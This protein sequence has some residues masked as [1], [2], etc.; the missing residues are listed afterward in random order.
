VQQS[1]IPRR[2]FSQIPR[3][4]LTGQVALITGPAKGMGHDIT[5]AIAREGADCI[6]A[7]RDL[8]AIHPVAERIRGLGRRAIVVKCDITVESDAKAAVASGVAEFGRIDCFVHVVGVHVGCCHP[9]CSCASFDR[10]ATALQGPCETPGWLVDDK[11]FEDVFSVNVKGAFHMAKAIAPVMIEK[12]GGRIVFLGGTYGMKAAPGRMVYAASKWALRG[13]T[14][15]LAAELGKHNINVNIVEPVRC[16]CCC[17]EWFCYVVV[18][19]PT[20][21][22]T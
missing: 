2:V 13:M 10:C 11:D 8:D 4:D 14:K 12:G 22:V 3:G 21:T 16:L 6:L 20:K 18:P 9:A 17:S 15:T 19:R 5:M 1:L 7:G